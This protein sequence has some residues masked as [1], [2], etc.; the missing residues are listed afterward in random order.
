MRAISMEICNEVN[1]EAFRHAVHCYNMFDF[2]LKYP[3]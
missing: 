2:E 3:N 1:N